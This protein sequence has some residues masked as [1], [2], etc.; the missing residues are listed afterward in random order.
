M[1]SPG[2]RVGLSARMNHD[3]ESARFF[4]PIRYRETI[5]ARSCLKLDIATRTKNRLDN[6]FPTCGMNSES[7]VA[8]QVGEEFN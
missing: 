8:T 1:F 6:A 7:G 4:V 2:A 5:S 3:V